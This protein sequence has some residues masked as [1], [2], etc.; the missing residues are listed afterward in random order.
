MENLNLEQTP[1]R[2]R[3]GLAGCGNIAPMHINA[4]AGL[5]QVRLVGLADP[6]RRAAERLR[7]GMTHVAVK[8]LPECYEDLN[9]L[10]QTTGPDV[11]H[12]CTPHHTHVPLAVAALQQGCHVLLEKPPAISLAG[13]AELSAAVGASNRTLGICFQNRYNDASRQARRLLQSGLAGKVKAARGYVTWNRGADYYGQAEWRGK[14]ASEG[15]GVMI[16]QA[17]HTLDLLIWLAGRPVEIEGSIANR[18]L[19]GIIEVEDTAE[20]VIK[21]ESGCIALFNAS[22]AYGDDAPVFLELSCDHLR[23]RLEADQIVLLDINGQPMPERQQVDWLAQAD[24]AWPGSDGYE[25]GPCL[26]PEDNPSPLGK[27]AWGQGHS[28]LISAFYQSLADPSRQ[29]PIDAESGSQALRA[30]LGLYASHRTGTAI[31][32]A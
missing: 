2:F 22:N 19:R 25:P 8:H 9:S 15:G 24:A 6:D 21:L 28:R 1:V 31:Q 3:T 16:N 17:I 13:L 26:S 30:L 4:L 23:I 10:I 5:P 14:W 32:L 11:V 20:M 12:I 29:F 7:A 18:H 27:A